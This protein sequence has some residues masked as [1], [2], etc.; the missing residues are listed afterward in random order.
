M[1]LVVVGWSVLEEAQQIT[2]GQLWVML[3][4]ASLSGDEKMFES[5]YIYILKLKEGGGT[6]P[7]DANLKEGTT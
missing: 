4:L 1:H 5:I 3:R 7:S 6:P 2:D